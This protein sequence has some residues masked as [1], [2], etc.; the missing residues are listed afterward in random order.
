LKGGKVS[1][2]VRSITVI[3]SEVDASAFRE[4]SINNVPFDSKLILPWD[5]Y[6]SMFI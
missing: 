1:G 5:N 3:S 6:K 2:E 4:A